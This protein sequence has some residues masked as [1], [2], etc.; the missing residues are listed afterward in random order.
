MLTGKRNKT[1]IDVFE[2]LSDGLIE[3]AARHHSHN[4]TTLHVPDHCEQRSLT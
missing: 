2:G 1:L 4:G 3:T